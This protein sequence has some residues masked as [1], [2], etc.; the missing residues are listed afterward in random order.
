[1]NQRAFHPFF[2]QRDGGERD[3]TEILPD[4]RK[5]RERKGEREEEGRD[6]GREGKRKGEGEKKEKQG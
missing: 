4:K 6:G 5:E 2:S 1:M 3:V